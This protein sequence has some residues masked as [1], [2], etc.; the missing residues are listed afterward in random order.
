MERTKA[1]SEPDSRHTQAGIGMMKLARPALRV[2]V[3]AFAAVF[4]LGTSAVQPAKAQT[5][6]VLY[7]F[8]NISASPTSPLLM[9]SAGDL[10]GTTSGG[11]SLPGANGTVYELVKSSG[12]YTQRILYDFGA[13]S[14]DG[15][16]PFAGVIMDSAGN[17]YGTTYAGGAAGKGT[18]FELVNSGG[19]YTEKVLYSFG[20]TNSDGINPQSGVIMD[21]AGNLYGTAY[22]GAFGVG[23]VFELVNASGSYTEKILYSFAGAPGDGNGPISLL[24]DSAGNLFGATLGGGTHGEGVLFELVNASGSYTEKVLYNFAGPPSDGRNP[25]GLLMD[26]AGNLYGTTELGGASANCNNYCGT[27]FELV[28]TSG[29]YAE[30]LLHSFTGGA[31]G[32]YPNATLIMDATGKIY[33]TST[34]GGSLGNGT[35]FELTNISGSYA[36]YV[37]H[38]F[39]G[40]PG[41]G[42]SPGT[43]IM[44]SAG[45][46]YGTTPN[47]GLNGNSSN[48]GPSG[49]GTVFEF[50]KASAVTVALT[51]PVLNFGNQLLGTPATT[52]SVI[53]NNIGAAN[54]TFASGAVTHSGPNVADFAIT[55]DGCSGHTLAPA[56]GNCTV[57]VTYTPS[58]LGS[59]AASLTFA[60]SAFGNP[61]SVPISGT[62]QDFSLTATTT[63]QTVSR[64]N[65]ANFQFFINPLGGFTGTVT[66]TCAGAPA[67]STCTPDPA[68]VAPQGNYAVSSV[69]VLT[70]GSSAPTFRSPGPS[71]RLPV[72]LW[73]ILAGLAGT[74]LLARFGRKPASIRLLAPPALLITLIFTVVI[75]TGS[76]GSLGAG[77]PGYHNPP[78]PTGT[79][80]LTISGTSG[81]LTHTLNLTLTVQ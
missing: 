68:S 8:T 23:T 56:T 71:P 5:E 61:Q 64:G 51:P 62:G 44:D 78:T 35:L 67:Y 39:A 69:I 37:L 21:S 30:K 12:S 3:G 63:S 74:S 1:N 4:L 20:A 46:L 7:N 36:E 66:L 42:T 70:S 43:P 77:H 9:D 79:Y 59:E 48:G 65:D 31:D 49:Y 16:N 55:S 29:N 53:V 73:I 76:C 14:S 18:V 81:G 6:T 47:G 52:Q 58:I 80:T 13:T 60:D 41:D 25:T 17:L 57:A 19:N 40:P 22:G 72:A 24:M 34:G 15:V 27:V 54:L 10:F 2:T 32:S 26:S 50:T 28:N 38:V 11:G 33:G 75:F 45:N